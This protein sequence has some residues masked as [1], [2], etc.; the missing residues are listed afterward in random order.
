[1]LR[2]TEP[3]ASGASSSGASSTLEPEAVAAWSGVF[4]DLPGMFLKLDKL[5]PNVG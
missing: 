1:M 2:M 3:A 5:N 4:Q